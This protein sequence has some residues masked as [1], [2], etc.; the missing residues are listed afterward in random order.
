MQ[1]KRDYNQP[2]FSTRRRRRGVGGRFLFIYGLVI[3]A[4]LVFVWAQFDRLQLMALDVVGLAPTATP[5]ASTW[6]N[7]GYDQYLQGD[8]VAALASFQRAA[9]QQ[10]DNVNY[11]YEYGRI[12]IELDDDNGYAAQAETI[13]DHM[14]EVTPNDPRGYVIKARAMVWQDDSANAIPWALRGLEIDP[15]FAPIHS[16]LARAYT[17]IGRYQQGLTFGEQAVQLDP[18]DPDTH[19]SYAIALIWVGEREAAI[20]QLEDAVNLNPNLT[21]TYFELAQ[22][23]INQNLEEYG[24]ATYE[25]ILSLEPFNAKALLRLCEVYFRVGQDQQAQG[26]CDDALELNPQYKQAYRQLGMVEFRRRNY[27]GAIEDFQQCVALGSTEIQCYYLRG[28]AHYY[29]GECDDAWNLLQ[30]S[31]VRVEGEGAPPGDPVLTSIQSG[32]ELVTQNCADYRGVAL[33]TS[34]PPTEP[35]PTPIGGLGG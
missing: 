15:N 14:I 1:I 31:L 7:Q 17:D 32:L 5:F 13:G 25:K 27:E 30:D 4:F 28:L 3:G 12:L 34:P 20:E 16:V 11:L 24:V 18:N 29:L 35:P 23:Y 10:P 22:Q 6:A 26:Y 19:R 8:V 33:P 9:Q 21:A 2:F